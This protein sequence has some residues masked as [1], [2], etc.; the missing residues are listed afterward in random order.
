MRQAVRLGDHDGTDRGVRGDQPVV[1]IGEQWHQIGQ[2]GRDRGAG[3]RRQTDGLVL[4]Y[5]L[6]G[7]KAPSDQ[8][9]DAFFEA[10][11]S[12]PAQ[13]QIF[14]GRLGRGNLPRQFPTCCRDW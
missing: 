13:K 8:I 1:K 14:L 4:F 3:D 5:R 12:R 7:E 2:A 10:E 9:A 6:L 11:R